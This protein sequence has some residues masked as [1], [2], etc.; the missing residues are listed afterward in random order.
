M[1]CFVLYGLIDWFI[2]FWW[3]CSGKSLIDLLVECWIAV[4]ACRMLGGDSGLLSGVCCWG[5]GV[6]LWV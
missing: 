3:D 4:F 6:G 1:C 5:C 2:V